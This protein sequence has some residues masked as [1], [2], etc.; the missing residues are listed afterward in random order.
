MKNEEEVYQTSL[1]NE[2][3]KHGAQSLLA[4]CSIDDVFNYV[5]GPVNKAAPSFH[6]CENLRKARSAVLVGFFFL[7]IAETAL[8]SGFCFCEVGFFFL[9]IE[10]SL[11][12]SGFYFWDIAGSAVLIVFFFLKIDESVL[13]SGFCFGEIAGSAVLVGFS[14]LEI[15]EFALQSGF[16]FCEIVGNGVL[17]SFYFCESDCLSNRVSCFGLSLIERIFKAAPSFY[18]CENLLIA[19]SAVLFGFFILE[20][21]SAV[22]GSFFILEIGSA[23]LVGFYFCEP[24]NWLNCVYVREVDFFFDADSLA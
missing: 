14:I 7:E 24:C 3:L 11:I 18:F 23:V 20:I 21:G 16:C 10:E 13:Q 19:W 1:T 4:S 17:G 2:Q 9:E 12:Q 15:E 5:T 22:P 8:Q 6:L